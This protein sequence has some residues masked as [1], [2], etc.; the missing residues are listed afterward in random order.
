MITALKWVKQNIKY[1]G[2]DASRVT[3]MGESAGG[4][5]V[6]A[7]LASKRTKG[8][9]S[10]AIHGSGPAAL[11]PNRTD[12]EYPTL[13]ESVSTAGGVIIASLGC[14]GLGTCARLECLRGVNE[15]TIAMSSYIGYPLIDH[16]YLENNLGVDGKGFVVNVP[17]MIG[18]IRDELAIFNAG[19]YGITSVDTAAHR[20]EPII[21][22]N[23]PGIP[24]PSWCSNFSGR[25]IQRDG[26]YLNGLRIYLSL[27]GDGVFIGKPW[28]S[29]SDV[30]V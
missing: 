11:L 13:S 23:K 19:V 27:M 4:I 17:V 25:G 18:I 7:L 26:S 21:P 15:T 22:C 2:G 6:R 8:L 16:F 20:R 1:F 29:T 12:S 9:I 28:F 10:D 5:A 3:I 24:N 30:C 14:G